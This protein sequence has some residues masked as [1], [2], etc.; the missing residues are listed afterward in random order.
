MSS[1]GAIL[2]VNLAVVTA[3]MVPLWLISMAKEDVS[4]VDIF[5]GLGFVLVAWMSFVL[6]GESGARGVLIAVLTTVWGVRLAGYLAWRN[7]GKGEDYRY[8]AMRKRIGPGFRWVSLYYVFGLQALLI[9][10]VSLPIQ[11]GQIGDGEHNITVMQGAG[12]ALWL[13]GMFFETVGDL[14]LARFKAAADSA[15]KIMDR[16]L[17]RYTR[18]PNYF[19]DFMAWWGLF[20]VAMASPAELLKNGWTAVGPVIMSILLVRISGAA[21]LEKS[22]RRRR[23]GYDDYIRRT[24]AFFPWPPKSPKP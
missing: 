22:L 23:P 19:G 24:S 12:V 18:H 17:W 9:W 5:W 8:Q 6:A 14:Q 16:G 4:I 21:L 11:V 3:A 7:L 2:L 20:F 13:I 10:I 15:G 1:I